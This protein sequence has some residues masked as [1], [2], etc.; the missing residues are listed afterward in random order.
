MTHQERQSLVNQYRILALLDKDNRSEYERNAQ[1][2]EDGHAFLYREVFGNLSESSSEEVGEEVHQ[3]LT[4]FRVIDSS[5][6]R[7]APEEQEQFNVPALTFGGFDGNEP[8][9]HSFARFIMEKM[10]L[11]QEHSY[12]DIN[13]HS[14]ASLPHYRGMLAAYKSYGGEFP[15]TSEY[16]QRL[17]NTEAIW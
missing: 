1:I 4:M 14:R 6:K 9:H 7:L 8:G 5:I 13:S 3:I 2:L 12:D 15:L 10:G 11:Y 17:A 16:L